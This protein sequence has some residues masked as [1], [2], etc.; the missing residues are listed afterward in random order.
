MGL[1]PTA[2]T[3]AAQRRAVGVRFGG[4]V[5]LPLLRI[6]RALD[7]VGVVIQFQVVPL[8]MGV[9]ALFIGHQVV[10]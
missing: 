6:G 4:V 8:F 1:A 2:N 3:I 9:H 10:R 7:S 5:Q